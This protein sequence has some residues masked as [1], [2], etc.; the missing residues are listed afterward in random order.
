M[1]LPA[2]YQNRIDALRGTLDISVL[3]ALGREPMHGYAI[4]QMIRNRPG[5]VL[6]VETGSLYRALHRLEKNKW[7]QSEGKL[8]ESERRAKDYQVTALRNE[9]VATDHLWWLRLL[10]AI[11]AVIRPE[12]AH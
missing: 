12:V 2:R 10:R 3:Q 4:A 1:D 11:S 7:V 6:T 9:Q 5:D 8:T